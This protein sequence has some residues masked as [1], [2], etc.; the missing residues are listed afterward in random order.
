MEE[1]RQAM[2]NGKG[3]ENGGTEERCSV[4]RIYTMA[5]GV[6]VRVLFSVSS[7]LAVWR[8]ATV[9]NDPTWW[10]MVSVNGFLYFEAYLTFRYRR[11]GEW[12][13]F[14][15]S[16]LMYLISTVPAIWIL[17]LQLMKERVT[18]SQ[19]LGDKVC[20]ES[21]NIN[22]NTSSLAA[23]PGITI[24]LYLPSH[25]WSLAL[26]QTLLFVLIVGRWLLPKGSLSRDQLSQ[27]LLVYIGIAADILEFS[28]EGL[29][30]EEVRC[31][32]VMVYWILSIWTWSLLQFTLG[33]TATKARKPRMAG[34][35]DNDKPKVTLM[36]CETEVWG[37]MTTIIMQDG[38]YLAMRLYILI[39][40]RAINQMM[41]FFTC[42]NM[43][44]M[45]LQFYRLFVIYIEKPGYHP[46]VLVQTIV[47]YTS[48]RGGSMSPTHRPRKPLGRHLDI[49]DLHETAPG[50]SLPLLPTLR[51][52]R[53]T[54]PSDIMDV[55]AGYYTLTVPD[56]PVAAK[57][58]KSKARHRKEPHHKED[59]PVSPLFDSAA[60]SSSTEP[61]VRT[62]PPSPAKIIT[63]DDM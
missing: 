41:I 45:L 55:E 32:Y 21:D 13:W 35:D 27:L 17:E 5:Q 22:M 31:D 25:H 57:N 15:P 33:L 47:R 4:P 28:T 58:K 62:Y 3:D 61:L 56:P 39:K 29:K 46:Q 42:K 51:E 1:K 12:K 53:P 8:V 7:I 34:I 30:M 10:L 40:M 50:Q 6:F 11:S 59:E 2:K 37:L 63:F 43:L 26:Q 19:A 38:P 24:P 54:S 36:C 18:E 49:P 44:V 20:L 23:F 60:N 52:K 16:V 48:R 9:K 14:C